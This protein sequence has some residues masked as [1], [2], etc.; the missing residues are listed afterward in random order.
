MAP[1]GL[2]LAVVP[3]LVIVGAAVTPAG[4]LAAQGS[5]GKGPVSGASFDRF[6]SLTEGPVAF[7]YRR[8]RLTNAGPAEDL[9]V[10]LFPATLP[11]GVAIL[12]IDVGL[13]QAVAVG[14]VVLFV[15]G[16]A[17]S[18]VDVG[19]HELAL[20]PGLQAGVGALV[21]LENRA[22]LRIDVT[23]HQFYDDGSRYRIWSLGLGLAV[24]PPAAGA[25]RR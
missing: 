12:G 18:M 19:F 8:S 11:L 16:G 23:R 17:S 7:G 10:R 15:K 6:G 5:F 2:A 4:S 1:I 9:A 13:M 3:L 21:R 14:P 22:A 20:V 25:G 24:L